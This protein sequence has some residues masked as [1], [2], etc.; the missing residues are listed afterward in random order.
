M[1]WPAR[2]VQVDDMLGLGGK[3][4][5]PQGSVARPGGK[6]TRVQKRPEGRQS[7]AGG[8]FAKKL[9]ARVKERIHIFEDTPCSPGL[10]KPTMRVST[11]VALAFILL[12]YFR[13]R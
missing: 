3:M 13:C 7:K 6:Q 8:G 9:P 5:L 11:P 10:D 1:R 12:S 2:L 4:W